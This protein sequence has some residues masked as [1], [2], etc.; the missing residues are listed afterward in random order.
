MWFNTI[1]RYYDNGHPS[2]TDE[3]LKVFVKANMIAAKE[4]KE[5][6]GI[7]YVD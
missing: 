6:T 7:E 3:G 4:Y 2:Y 1:K 5:I